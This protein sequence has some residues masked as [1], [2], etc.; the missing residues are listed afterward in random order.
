MSASFREEASFDRN[1]AFTLI[2]RAIEELER[3]L[4]DAGKGRLFEALRPHLQGDR[5][6]RPYAEIALEFGLSEGAV[7]VS[8]HRLRQQYRGLLHEEIAHTVTRPE[9]IEEEMRYLFEVVSR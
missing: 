3:E 1:W 8:V 7:K 9:E 4:R 2:H 6:G 5:S